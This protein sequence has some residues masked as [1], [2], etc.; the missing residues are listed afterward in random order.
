MRFGVGPRLGAGMGAMR[1]SSPLVLKTIFAAFLALRTLSLSKSGISFD[2]LIHRGFNYDESYLSFDD[3]HNYRTIIPS[4]GSPPPFERVVVCIGGFGDSPS[5][6]DPLVERLKSEPGVC[7]TLPPTPGWD[8][9]DG[10]KKAR[11]LSYV[12]WKI[13]CRRAI[14]EANALGEEVV[15]IA[16]STGATVALACLLGEEDGQGVDRVVFT[17]ANLGPAV[18]DRKTKALLTSRLG[19]FLTYLKPVVRKKLR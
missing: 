1:E 17:G 15:L 12:D 16:H 10:F 13:A 6:F 4:V 7:V 9:W 8:R 3:V 5:S 2:D 18:S 14:C 19:K 11:Q